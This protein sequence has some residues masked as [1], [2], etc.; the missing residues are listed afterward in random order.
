MDQKKYKALSL[1]YWCVTIISI[2]TMLV[3][4]IVNDSKEV[5]SNSVNQ[6]INSISIL[7]MLVGIPFALKY[8]HRKTLEN[9]PQGKEESYL[10]Q[11]L[12]RHFNLRYWIIIAVMV[13]NFLAYE[14][15]GYGTA[16]YCLAIC[17]IVLLAFCRP[18]RPNLEA[19]LEEMTK[20]SNPG[21]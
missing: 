9:V 2:V 15:F 6:T 5:E 13:L 11:Y 12:F 7:C 4:H 21:E 18:S 17:A 19:T 10:C 1:T 3:F 8:Y 16:V 20:K 14:I